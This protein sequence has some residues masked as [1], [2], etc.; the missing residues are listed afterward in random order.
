V[1]LTGEGSDEY[2]IGYP[3]EALRPVLDIVDKVKTV[4]RSWLSALSPKAAKMF[5]P[6]PDDTFAHRLLALSSAFEADLVAQNSRSALAGQMGRRD[7]RSRAASLVLAQSHLVSV[8][9]RNDRLGMAWG[10]ETRFP[11]LPI[12]FAKLAINLP[13]RYKLRRTLRAHDRRHPFIVDKWAIRRVAAQLLPAELAARPKRGLPVSITRRLSVSPKF[14]SDGFVADIYTLD[15]TAIE[16]VVSDGPSE[17]LT[18]LIL[19]EVWGQ[20]FFRG[21]SPD[22]MREALLIHTSTGAMA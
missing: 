4:P 16:M 14:F 5:W 22:A 8:L 11:L 21:A 9:H 1:L 3:D 13:D 15:E 18:R 20:L 19:L 17:W 10:V 12:E 2:L 6:R 7:R